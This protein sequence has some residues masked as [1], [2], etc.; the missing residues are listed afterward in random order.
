MSKT[1]FIEKLGAELGIA[2][3]KLTDSA[4]LR[5]FPAWDSMGRMAVVA[6]LDAELGFELPPGSLQKCQ[7]VGDLVALVETK[8]TS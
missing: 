2:P 1:Q 6:M 8:L 4:P 5:S 7:T 3:A